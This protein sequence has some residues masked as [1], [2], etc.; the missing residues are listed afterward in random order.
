MA[1]AARSTSLPTNPAR[2]CASTCCGSSK[3]RISRRE[4]PSSARRSSIRS[5]MTVTWR[6]NSTRLQPFSMRIQKL[7]RPRLNKRLP[8]SSAS[9]PSA[10]LRGQFPNASSCSYAS[11]TPR[12]QACSSRSNSQR[13]ISNSLRFTSTANCGAACAHP[14]KSCMRRWRSSRVVIPSRAWPSARPPRNMS[15]RMYSCARSTIAGR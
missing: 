4:K 14:R 12:R 5:T 9:T 6:Q 11:S 10:S 15:F 2:R 1:R 3:W 8:R 7:R 13:I